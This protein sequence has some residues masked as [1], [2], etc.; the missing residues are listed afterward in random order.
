MELAATLFLDGNPS[1]AA[2]L[3]EGDVDPVHAADILADL[4][5]VVL[6]RGELK[7]AH[8]AALFIKF[9]PQEL[10]G[11]SAPEQ[12]PLETRRAIIAGIRSNKVKISHKTSVLKA[13][14]DDDL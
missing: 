10:P 9:F 14:A 13:D 1:D 5:A 3:L 6:G 11:V 7:T 2:K 12:L 8:V 4:R